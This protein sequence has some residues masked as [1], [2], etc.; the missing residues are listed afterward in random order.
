MSSDDQDLLKSIFDFYQVCTRREHHHFVPPSD[1]ENFRIASCVSKNITANKVN[2][3]ADHLLDWTEHRSN[4][5][6][7]FR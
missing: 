7:C 5:P 1:L 6:Q 4:C 2:R 3:M